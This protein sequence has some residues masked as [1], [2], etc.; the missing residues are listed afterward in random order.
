MLYHAELELPFCGEVP[1]Q[2]DVQHEGR[3]AHEFCRSAN[4]RW[5][6]RLSNA[7]AS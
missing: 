3:R 5:E 6:A 7:D 4:E 1:R 2:S